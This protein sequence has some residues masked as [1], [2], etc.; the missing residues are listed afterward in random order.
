[1]SRWLQSTPQPSLGRL[2]VTGFLL[3]KGMVPHGVDDYVVWGSLIQSLQ[4]GLTQTDAPGCTQ[5]AP[6]QPAP[7][8]PA[9]ASTE[10]KDLLDFEQQLKNLE[11][12]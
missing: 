10:D 8:Q 7:A 11:L 9:P 4:L 2:L 12:E 3:N 1:M 6:A 5:P